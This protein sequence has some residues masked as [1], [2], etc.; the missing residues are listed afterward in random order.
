MLELPPSGP[1][2]AASEALPPGEDLGRL[3]TPGPRAQPRGTAHG[4]PSLSGQGPRHVRFPRW[5]TEQGVGRERGKEGLGCGLVDGATPAPS[6]QIP[7][8]SWE[9]QTS[10][11]HVGFRGCDRDIYQG[12][13]S[14][15][16]RQL[17]SLT[18]HF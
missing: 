15:T 5:W 14:G 16:I 7:A 13:G 9:P 10:K 1:R 17:A 2:A 12:R 6:H 4:E 3:C 11:F 8:V 18:H